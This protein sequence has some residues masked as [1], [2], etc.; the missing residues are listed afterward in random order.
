MYFLLNSEFCVAPV[1]QKSHAVFLS[2]PRQR[3]KNKQKESLYR[4]AG[5]TCPHL[6]QKLRKGYCF[7][8]KILPSDANINPLFCLDPC[9]ELFLSTSIM[10][11]NK[12]CISEKIFSTR[13]CGIPLPSVNLCQ[14]CCRS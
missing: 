13:F 11:K 14:L 2:G 12:N 8:A 5:S 3:W 6:S 1:K 10:F 7:V 9:P 4:N